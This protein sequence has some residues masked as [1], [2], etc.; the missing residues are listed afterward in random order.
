M[1]RSPL[2]WVGLSPFGQRLCEGICLELVGMFFLLSRVKR[3]ALVPKSV[4]DFG[5]LMYDLALVVGGTVCLAE[6]VKLR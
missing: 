5:L 1:R 4:W 6:A 2:W 3:N